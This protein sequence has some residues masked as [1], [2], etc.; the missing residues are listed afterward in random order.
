MGISNIEVRHFR[1]PFSGLS[2]LIGAML[3]IPALIFMLI[4][5]PAQ[6]A[7][8]YLTSYL[9]FCASM[10]LMFGS[11]ATYHLLDISE[12]GLKRLK[13]ID[14]IAIFIMI[15]GTYTP[16]C[17]IGLEGALSWFMFT[18]IWGVAIV[19][20]M[21]KIFWLHAPRWLSTLLYVA[22]G[23]VAIL[24]YEP[25]SQNLSSES[26]YW[27]IAG[28]VVYTLGAVIYATKWPNIHQK[29]FNF[30]DLW[31]VFVLGGA[32]CHYASIAF[33]L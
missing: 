22:M 20:V 14:H 11:S 8:T 30:H 6:N 16:Y 31:H 5:L 29:Y 10:F 15:A 3:T 17:L 12:L 9:V 1:E 13:R 28:G 23:W 19:G 33:Y 27:L 25:L 4:N 2:H 24:I 21:V 32:A 7:S 18:L 26:I